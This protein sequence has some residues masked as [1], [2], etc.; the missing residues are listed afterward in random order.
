MAGTKARVFSPLSS[1][2]TTLH[3]GALCHPGLEQ[4]GGLLKA[5]FL[6]RTEQAGS[7]TLAP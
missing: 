4:K 2:N 5:T 7:H 3:W 6:E 1:T